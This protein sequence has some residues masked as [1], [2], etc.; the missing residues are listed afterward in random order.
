[1]RSHNF[2]R[3]LIVFVCACPHLI[4]AQAVESN[5]IDGLYQL[6]ETQPQ[7]AIAQVDQLFQHH[8]VRTA[9]D[10]TQLYMIL[11]DAWYYDENIL[12]STR[13]MRKAL[14]SMPEIFPQSKRI[15]A[16]NSLGQNLS[17]MGKVDS[18]ILVYQ[19][20]L[21]LARES[22]DST[23]LANLYFNI[24][25]EYRNK[26]AYQLCLT[27]LD[28]SYRI[29]YERQ[30][31]SA[32]SSSLRAVGSMND[33]YFDHASARQN[34]REALRY[35]SQEDAAQACVL[36]TSMG[37]SYLFSLQIDSAH[38]CAKQAAECFANAS[39][40]NNIQYLYRLQGQIALAEQDTLG[41]IRAF[42]KTARQAQA[43]GD[44]I[45][46]YIARSLEIKVNP[47]DQ[48][49]EEIEALL[50]EEVIRNIPDKQYD[51]Y[52]AYTTVLVEKG[53]FYEALISLRKANEI[54]NKF[55]EDRNQKLAQ[56]QAVRFDLLKKET[57]VRLA[58]E[59]I[60][61]TRNQ[62]AALLSLLIA[63]LTALFTILYV[64]KRKEK[65][66]L[67]QQKLEQERTLMQQ[68]SEVESAAFRAQ[69]N[70]H[71]IF[72]ALNS[73]K[74]LIV[75]QR[76]K[77]A[78]VYISK[79]SKLVRNMLDNSR[80]KLISLG[81]ELETLE[82][83][84]KLEQLRFRDGFRY[85]ISVDESLQADDQLVLPALLQPF[86]ENAIWHGFKNN[87]RSNQLLIA[88]RQTGPWLNLTVEDNGVGRQDP[89]E[90]SKH[91]SHGTAICRARID[92]YL[93]DG[94]KGSLQIDDLRDTDEQSV[95]TRI[96]ISI[97]IHPNF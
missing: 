77:E 46:Y 95:G 72:N 61:S 26:A 34:Y 86:V 8:Q 56:S 73:I 92:N 62:W 14:A 12:E 11:S 24:G 17:T 69:V 23:E 59:S 71:F 18:A 96:R 32:L 51:L 37:N 88:I 94:R 57:E 31:S 87:P 68:I 64:R 44:A 6:L 76:D 91:H 79:F 45:E 25:L 90:T 4:Q 48:S 78:A 67:E 19:Q 30:D 74:G 33:L 97:P 83:Y 7:Q 50:N 20:G 13:Y 36:M 89:S 22:Q 1:M 70:P 81:R 49:L 42:Q 75:N 27:Y 47:R 35:V 80:S 15:E 65:L 21:H 28:S 29:V 41:A 39:D 16:H 5:L 53:M 52:Q 3:L 43:N 66:D 55:L 9:S 93:V 63:L 60:R 2:I 82:M 58:K 85:E 40:Q 84:I 38:I 54:R 10:S